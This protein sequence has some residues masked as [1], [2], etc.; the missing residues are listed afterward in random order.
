MTMYPSLDGQ[1]PPDPRPEPGD[2]VAAR[3]YPTMGQPPPARRGAEVKD[4]MFPSL[5]QDTS[6][7][8]THFH[9]VEKGW[10]DDAEDSRPPDP[11]ARAPE[12]DYSAVWGDELPE[13]A[14]EVLADLRI[15][16]RGAERLAELAEA[17][18]QRWWDQTLAA[19]NEEL[20]ADPDHQRVIGDAVA[21]IERFGDEDLPAEMGAFGSHPG[22]LRMLARVQREL[23]RRRY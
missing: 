11:R 14:A 8:E 3:M 19:W 22:L 17:H 18:S 1:T 2:P 21:V 12:T 23:N 5:R 6:Q 4:R 10:D 13:G 7:S 20:Y 9:G 16:Q 15:D